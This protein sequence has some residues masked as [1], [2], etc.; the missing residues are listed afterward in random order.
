M[1]QGNGYDAA[2]ASLDPA[3]LSLRALRRFRE[4]FRDVR[5]ENFAVK[6][7]RLAVKPSQHAG[8]SA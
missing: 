8:K 3:R 2:M 7:G 6:R 1:R 5:P 4:R